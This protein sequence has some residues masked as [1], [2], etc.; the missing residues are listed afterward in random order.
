VVCITVAA[1]R[2]GATID[3]ARRRGVHLSDIVAATDSRQRHER[4]ENNVNSAS[5]VIHS[6]VCERLEISLTAMMGSAQSDVTSRPPIGG[7]WRHFNE[8]ER[9]CDIR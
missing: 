3:S 8:W 9:A 7:P 4:Q 2:A 5:C 1:H 6:G